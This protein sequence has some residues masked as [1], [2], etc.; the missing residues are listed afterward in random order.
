MPRARGTH[1][2]APGVPY[3]RVLG[4]PE[5]YNHTLIYFATNCIFRGEYK[6]ILGNLRSSISKCF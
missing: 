6:A 5:Q 3:I 4:L 1:F 2:A